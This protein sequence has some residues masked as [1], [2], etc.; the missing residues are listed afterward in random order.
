[1]LSLMATWVFLKYI[2]MIW[3]K[4]EKITANTIQKQIIQTV[5]F[6]NLF[7]E[8]FKNWSFNFMKMPWILSTW[9]FN[10]DNYVGKMHTLTL[11]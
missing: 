5:K 11:L 7:R 2:T 4:G 3:N 1:M 8:G 6:I 9:I 10:V